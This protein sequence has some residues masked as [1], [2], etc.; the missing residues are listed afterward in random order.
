MLVLP[1]N[2]EKLT[3]AISKTRKQGRVRKEFTQNQQA[4]RLH[5]FKKQEYFVCVQVCFF[6][7][8]AITSKQKT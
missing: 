7:T 4:G 8:K 6:I 1:M 5:G 2:Y 3:M